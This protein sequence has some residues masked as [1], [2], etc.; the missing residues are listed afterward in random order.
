MIAVIALF[1]LYG[2]TIYPVD[3]NTVD[4][5][6]RWAKQHLEGKVDKE[7]FF[8]FFA[9]HEVEAWLL[10]HPT[11]FPNPIKQHVKKISEYPEKIDNNKPPAKRVNEIYLKAAH[12]GPELNLKSNFFRRVNRNEVT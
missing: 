11:I 5:R 8:Q 4:K 7:N 1:N 10:S 3:R 12:P 9:V 6:Y 2:P